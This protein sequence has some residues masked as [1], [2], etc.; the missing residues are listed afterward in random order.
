MAKQT[1]KRRSNAEERAEKLKPHQW[2]KGESGNPLGGAHPNHDPIGKK[3][4]KL[5]S[6]EVHEVITLLLESN[7]LQLYKLSRNKKA[8]FL[9]K[10]IASVSIDAIKKN[11]FE[12]LDKLL[13]RSIGPVAQRHEHT[14][15]DGGPIDS[16]SS[17]LST[18][19]R[20][21]AIDELRR[22]RE[23]AGDA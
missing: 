2:K 6:D 1:Q 18:E 19:E 13:N 10:W 16:V 23:A 9:Q 15:R 21:K 4:K 8:P 7:Y 14:G 17:L 12:L 11:N 22:A 20:R 5:T 3:L